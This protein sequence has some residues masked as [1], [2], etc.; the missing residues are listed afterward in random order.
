MSRMNTEYIILDKL[1]YILCVEDYCYYSNKMCFDDL[2]IVCY[3]SSLGILLLQ[4]H[5]LHFTEL[6]WRERDASMSI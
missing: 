6:R 1:L 3:K 4:E 2:N 5:F